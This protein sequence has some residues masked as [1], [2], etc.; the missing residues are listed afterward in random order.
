MNK[1]IAARVALVVGTALMAL[2][3]GGL[4]FGAQTGVFIGNRLVDHQH[5]TSGDGGILQGLSPV[6]NFYINTNNAGNINVSSAA[7]GNIFLWEPVRASFFAGRFTTPKFGAYAVNRGSYSITLGAD[8]KNAAHYSGILGYGNT[9]EGM[10]FNSYIFGNYMRNTA[11]NAILIGNGDNLYTSVNNS[12][13]TIKFY[14]VATEPAMTIAPTASYSV[15]SNIGIGI[16][17]PAYKLDVNGEVN[18]SGYY[19][20]G[21]LISTSPVMDT[22]RVSKAGD[23]MT[24]QLTLQGSSLT[25]TGNAF[26]VGTSTLVVSG[27]KVGI[28]TSTP[29]TSLSFGELGNLIGINT[30][31]GS[32]TG[33]IGMA[34]GSALANTRGA[35]GLFYGNEYSVGGNRGNVLLRAGNISTSS[36]D[37]SIVLQTGNATDV[38]RLTYAGNV[39]I[40]TTAPTDRLYVSSAATTGDSQAVIMIEQLGSNVSARNRLVSGITSGQN[41]YFAIETRNQDGNITEKMRFKDNNIGIGDTAPQAKLVVNG[42]VVSSGT[43][44]ATAYTGNGAA[45]ANLV[46]KV[47]SSA[48]NGQSIASTSDL[49]FATAT[50]TNRG[51]RPQYCEAH[52]TFNNSAGASR[53]YTYAMYKNGVKVAG[54]DYVQTVSGTSTEFVEIGWDETSTAGVVNFTFSVRSSSASGEQTIRHPNILCFE[55]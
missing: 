26:S 49:F 13:N 46:T 55:Y 36:G 16:S 33:Y 29:T 39:G 17:S 4:A 7:A 3:I 45:L 48:V 27:G 20:N 32:D 22:A 35:F 8:N 19:V 47:S 34:A 5:T 31:D 6:G 23:T 40:G 54:G 41:P 24:G 52:M 18:S 15:T 10:R 42:N 44:S 38:M 30:S 11:N 53:D 43:I 50:I 37:G 21:N 9:N 25:V 28:N 12:T 2:G 14:N 1:K 51:S